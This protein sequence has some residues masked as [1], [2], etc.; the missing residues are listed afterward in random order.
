MRESEFGFSKLPKNKAVLRVFLHHLN[1]SETGKAAE[2]T[3]WKHH[4]GC[5]NDEE[6]GR[7]IMTDQ[8]AREKVL[9]LWRVR[10]D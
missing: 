7:I 2:K 10:K 1:G 5:D 4:L 6:T 9:N 3:V 8:M